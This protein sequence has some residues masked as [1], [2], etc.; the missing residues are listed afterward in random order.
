[1]KF[2]TLIQSVF[3]FAVAHERRFSEETFSLRNVVP[4]RSVVFF[5][6][7]ASFLADRIDFVDVDD[8]RR[9]FA[10]F[11]EQVSNSRSAET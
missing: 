4:M 2:V 8:A 5:L 1:M 6:L 10:R 9:A 11:A 7:A 3:L